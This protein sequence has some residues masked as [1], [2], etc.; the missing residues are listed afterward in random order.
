MLNK[1]M[2]R[3]LTTAAGLWVTAAIALIVGIDL[4][5]Q[6]L[7]KL[8]SSVTR[9]ENGNKDCKMTLGVMLPARYQP[10]EIYHQLINIE[11]MHKIDIRQPGVWLHCCGVT[12]TTPISFASLP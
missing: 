5:M 1:Q 11:S 9:S 10:A 6:A 8:R 3:G 4:T 2:A 12:F 7:K